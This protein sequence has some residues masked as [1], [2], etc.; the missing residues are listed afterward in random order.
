MQGVVCMKVV[1]NKF[2]L[3]SANYK[4]RVQAAKD[5]GETSN[6]SAVSSLVSALD[7]SSSFVITEAMNALVNI[8]DSR[9]TEYIAKK[10][11]DKSEFIRRD[12]AL[13][14]GKM[15]AAESVDEMIQQ[16]QVET[17]DNVKLA[18]V[19]ALGEL[20]NDK[21]IDIIKEFLWVENHSMRRIAADSLELLGD[22]KWRNSIEG[23][24]DDFLSIL[25]DQSENS[26]PILARALNF[27]DPL[28]R[29]NV[30]ASLLKLKNNKTKDVLW[31]KLDSEMEDG[32][33]F[34]ED[35]AIALAQLGDARALPALKQI[36]VDENFNYSSASLAEVVETLE[37]VGTDEAQEI[38]IAALPDACCTTLAELAMAL[39][40]LES[41]EAVYPLID[42][43]EKL[44][45]DLYTPY[46]IIAIIEA[47]GT[48]ADKEAIQ[49]IN[50]YAQPHISIE[51]RNV[52]VKE[53]K[54]LQSLPDGE[55]Y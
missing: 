19:W 16:L 44:K 1:F 15:N 34:S 23:K 27:E 48:I 43:L 36:L 32:D 22:K 7:D 11:S 45:N 30:L 10:M 37:D 49:I 18:I 13:T 28:I 26:F 51:I 39:G 52:A 47:L 41:E 46:E 5:L 3:R 42:K 25:E 20:G 21:A 29:K 8:G 35:I 54:H 6:K 40:K 38:L 24:A 14:L 17:S 9:S 55:E 53:L 33:Y 12:A 2:K 31:K 50:Y 4:V